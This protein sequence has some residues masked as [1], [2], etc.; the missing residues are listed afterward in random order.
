MKNMYIYCI[1]V[2]QRKAKIHFTCMELG[3]RFT[4]FFGIKWHFRGGLLHTSKWA[5]KVTERFVC[6]YSIYFYFYKM[7]MFDTAL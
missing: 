3:A 1:S 4:T 5:E 2:C 6:K 7:F